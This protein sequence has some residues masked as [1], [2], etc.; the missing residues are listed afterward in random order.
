MTPA[1]NTHHSRQKTRHS[2]GE[3]GHPGAKIKGAGVRPK[4]RKNF[5]LANQQLHL[6]PLWGTI[7]R[8][9]TGDTTSASSGLTL[10]RC[11]CV[12]LASPMTRLRPLK[13]KGKKSK[14]V[15]TNKINKQNR[16]FLLDKTSQKEVFHFDL[17]LQMLAARRRDYHNILTWLMMNL[18]S[19]SSEMPET[20][21]IPLRNDA[22]QI[23]FYAV[24][25]HS[26]VS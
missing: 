16:W 14:L 23:E 2:Q 24:T 4:S 19:F 8:R 6:P 15:K 13:E 22:F 5:R 3:R 7:W 25:S 18:M 9:W 12:S 21:S 26:R 11:R 20:F 10:M 17:L 1:P